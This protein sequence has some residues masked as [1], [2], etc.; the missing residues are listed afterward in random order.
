MCICFIILHYKKAE[1]TTKCVD[2]I[3]RMNGNDRMQIVIVDNSIGDDSGQVI[4]EH[5]C[6]YENIHVIPSEANAG[7]SRANNIG[8]RYA[9]THFEPDFIVAANNDIEF[10]QPDFTE[11]LKAVYRQTHFAVLG[12][13]VIH[14]V[15]GGHQSPIDTRIRTVAEAAATVRKNRI[16]LKLSGILYPLLNMLMSG[17]YENKGNALSID[18]ARENENVVL[19]GACLI[20]SKDFLDICDKAFDPETDFFYEEYILAHRCEQLGL[21]IVY[22][23][24]IKIRHESG[25][26]TKQSYTDKKKRVQFILSNTMKSCQVY[27]NFIKCSEEGHNTS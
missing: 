19:L 4:K 22:D 27:L 20:F 11:L 6:G 24:A 10:L 16:A 25:A 5:Y 3:L 1:E 23:P 18:Y 2:S 14:A 15:T 17:I 12:P 21:K 7:F 9:L 26:T 8:Y 13:D